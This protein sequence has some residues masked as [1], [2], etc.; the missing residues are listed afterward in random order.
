M[1]RREIRY[2]GDH[3]DESLLI[4]NYGNVLL[5]AE[6]KFEL[7]GLMYCPRYS[8]EFKVF[9]QGTISFR[10]ACKKIIIKNITSDCQL[11][12]S[13]VVCKEVQ[14]KSAKGK[15]IILIGPT[16]L[17]SQA[18]L[19]EEAVLQFKGRPLIT[20]CSL[21]LSARMGPFNKKEKKILEAA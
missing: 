2:K 21:G 8:V 7:S 13:E 18:N 10:G 20:N 6:G 12:L 3:K 14:V 11:D 15:A 9:G 17:I 16:K 4:S 1:K 5:V 19:E